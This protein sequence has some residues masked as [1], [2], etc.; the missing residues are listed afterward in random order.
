MRKRCSYIIFVA[1]TSVH[2][3]SCRCE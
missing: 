1:D 2:Y 3:K